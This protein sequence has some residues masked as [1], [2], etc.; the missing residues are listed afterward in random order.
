MAMQ[1]TQ[2]SVPAPTPAPSEPTPVVSKAF[3]FYTHKEPDSTVFVPL[4]DTLSRPATLVNRRRREDG[5][6]PLATIVFSKG[7]FVTFDEAVAKALDAAIKRNPGNY[8]HIQPGAVNDKSV[9][10]RIDALRKQ[11]VRAAI[12]AAVGID[13]LNA[14]IADLA[15]S[16]LNRGD[17]AG[18]SQIAAAAETLAGA[19]Q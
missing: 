19:L 12:G 14:S 2:T 15:Q 7:R 18:A 4:D 17:T 1:P 9:A 6:V 10:L 3:T 11:D 13:G 16:R 8:G 5:D